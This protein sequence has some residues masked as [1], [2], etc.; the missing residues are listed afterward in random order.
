MSSEA[1]DRAEYERDAVARAKILGGKI[2]F[3]KGRSAKFWATPLEE[4]LGAKPIDESEWFR[5]HQPLLLEMVNTDEGRE[6]LCIPAEYGKIEKFD[7][8]AVYWKTGAFWIDDDGFIQE[9][10]RADFRVGAK[11][12]NVIRYRWREFCKLAK[13]FYEKEYKGMK[14]YRPVLRV[15]GELVAAHATDTSYPDPGANASVVDPQTTVDGT[16]RRF[17]NVGSGGAATSG[18]W[19]TVHDDTNATHVITTDTPDYLSNADDWFYGTDY[20]L[21]IRRGCAIFDTSGIGSATISAGV[22]SWFVEDAYD[23]DN[24][25]T[26]YIALVESA[27]A[28][29]DD[30]AAGDYQKVGLNGIGGSFLLLNPTELTAT[31]GRYDLSAGGAG[32]G[33][34]EVDA[35]VDWTMDATGRT[36]ISTSGVTK[37][38]LRHGHDTTDHQTANTPSA[39]AAA[40]IYSHIY[41]RSADHTGTGSDPKLVV[42][43]TAITTDVKKIS[44]I[45][46][47]SVKKINGIT[48]ANTKKFLGVEF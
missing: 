38:G 16:L 36:A 48:A 10:W 41:G 19:D 31:S 46:Q 23:K 37:L 17:L 14:I 30:L 40:S 9:E 25:A 15:E 12:S 45:A 3:T 18:E 39:S 20:R 35:Y 24:D 28:S 11:W 5:M 1:I 13:T 21:D 43:Y 4:R 6:L 2:P 42:T 34:V 27:P 32:G 44:G 7:R 26:A 22:A 8:N 33:Q 29:N 47:A